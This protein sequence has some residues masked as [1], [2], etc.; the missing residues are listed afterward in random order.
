MEFSFRPR[1][2]SGPPQLS[3]LLSA[4]DVRNGH[5]H[6][7]GLKPAHV[8]AALGPL[9]ALTA[10]RE[11]FDRARLPAWRERT[12]AWWSRRCGLFAIR[13][14]RLRAAHVAVVDC[15]YGF[16]KENKEE[17]DEIEENRRQGGDGDEDF[18]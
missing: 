11:P 15:A 18:G 6:D 12:R 17:G 14:A 8:E 13:L 5:S 3:A 7:I 2:D 9:G 4:R 16:Q 1:N 10:W